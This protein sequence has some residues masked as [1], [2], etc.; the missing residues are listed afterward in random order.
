MKNFLILLFLLPLVSA[1]CEDDENLCLCPN[2]TENYQPY[3]G[4]KYQ[5]PDNRLFWSEGPGC[6]R[7]LTCEMSNQTYFVVDWEDTEI[8]TRPHPPSSSIWINAENK[9]V[10]RTGKFVN[11]MEL[12]GIVCED[13]KWYITKYPFGVEYQLPETWELAHINASELACKPYKTAIGGFYCDGE[14]VDYF[15]K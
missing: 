10:G 2:I 6:T 15:N 7:N 5:Y 13:M 14:P 9:D 12:F 1:G 4:W 3:G 11:L 8:P